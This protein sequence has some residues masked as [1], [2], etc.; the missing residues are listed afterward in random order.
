VS[1]VTNNP[2]HENQFLW[3][4]SIGT[5]ITYCTRITSTKIHCMKPFNLI[6]F[7]IQKYDSHTREAAVATSIITD[8]YK[9]LIHHSITGKQ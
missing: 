8:S 2:I 7:I 9:K 3:N 5:A 1:T 4:Q 6:F